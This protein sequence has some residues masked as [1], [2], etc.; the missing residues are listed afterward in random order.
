MCSS[1]RDEGNFAF[2][3]SAIE[4][5]I[6]FYLCALR[7]YLGSEVQLMVTFTDFESQL[8]DGYL[9]DRFFPL[10]YERLQ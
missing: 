1:G 8:A 6:R 9:E 10:I 3:L 7:A 4:M 5:Q 2:E